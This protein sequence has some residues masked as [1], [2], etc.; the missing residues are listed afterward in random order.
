MKK[1]GVLLINLGTPDSPGTADVRRYLREFLNDPRVIDISAFRRFMLVNGIIVPRRAPKSAKLYRQLWEM[2]DGE[3]PLWTFGKKL[4]SLSQERFKNENVTVHFAM[5]Y[6]NPSLDSVLAEMKVAAYDQI[7]ILPLFPHNASAS[8]GSA[9]EKSLKII[10]KWWSIPDVKI[11]ST[12]YN[13]PKYISAFVENASKHEVAAFDH[14]IFSYHGLPVRQIDKIHPKLKCS[15]CSCDKTFNED[16]K[17]CYRNQCYETSRLIVAQ[18][19]I[20]EEDYTVCFQSRLGKTPWLKPYSD[21]V[22]ADLAKVG[23]KKILALSPAFIADCLETSFEIG[24]E[25]QEI[26][27]ERGGD[28][29]QLVESLN[30]SSAWVDCIED[31]IRS[32]F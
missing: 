11:V 17:L 18:L 8:T 21:H 4:R 16:Y 27:E 7:V 6:Q 5:R 9:I 30:D 14:V 23:K 24:V 2:W 13:H 19:N 29:V 28:K 32:E 12:F 15:D 22:V 20:S 25:Y 3:S 26:F 1:T 10:Q 31:L